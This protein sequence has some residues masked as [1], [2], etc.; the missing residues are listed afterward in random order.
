MKQYKV[1]I[2]GATGAVGCEFAE[3]CDVPDSGVGVRQLVASVADP[4]DRTVGL[5]GAE[6]RVV[7]AQRVERPLDSCR[8]GQATSVGAP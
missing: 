1:A 2:L 3:G 8:S 6:H 7:G 5:P 4:A